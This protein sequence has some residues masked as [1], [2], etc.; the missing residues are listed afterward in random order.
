MSKKLAL[1]TAVLAAMVV[2]SAWGQSRDGGRSGPSREERIAMIDKAVSN[3]ATPLTD[4]QKKKIGDLFDAHDKAMEEYQPQIDQ[5]QQARKAALDSGDKDKLA[6]VQKA[7]AELNKTMNAKFG[8]KIEADVMN[9]LTSEQQAAWRAGTSVSVPAHDRMIS[10]L[11]KGVTLTDEQKKTIAELLAARDKAIQEL[12]AQDAPR[13]KEL[14]QAMR[15]AIASGD[16]DKI[17]QAQKEASEARKPANELMQKFQTDLLAVLTDEHMLTSIP[18]IYAVGDINGKYMLAHAAYREAE[19]AVN[20]ILGKRDIMRYEAVPSVIYTN[21]EVACIGETEE[22]AA[23]KGIEYEVAKVPLAYSGRYLAE[24]S[25]TDGIC[26]ILINEK[27]RNI[28]G[29]HMIGS[30]A[31]EIIAS[32]AIMIETQMRVEDVKELIFPHPTVGEIIR[33]GIFKF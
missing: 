1:V 32:A 16:K 8:T 11:F 2:F 18:N 26:K 15:E 22:T 28:I 13:R 29:V 20:H 5:L 9:V 4:E 25:V 14:E 31:S 7:W 27:Y 10:T 19:V 33:D 17:L 23:A 24:N 21:P 30:Y 12:N 6:E 3:T